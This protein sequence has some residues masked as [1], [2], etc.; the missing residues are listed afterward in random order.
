MHGSLLKKPFNPSAPVWI[1]APTEPELF[2]TDWQS[3]L[4]NENKGSELEIR[5]EN[6]GVKKVKGCGT[7]HCRRKCSAVIPEALEKLSRQEWTMLWPPVWVWGKLK[8]GQGMRAVKFPVGPQLCS[9]G[10]WAFM[11][12]SWGSPRVSEAW[13]RLRLTAEDGNDLEQASRAGE[14]K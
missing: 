1:T 6:R 8:R 13:E 10:L 9:D 2:M 4:R 12:F 14:S 3:H 7:L 11:G 5:G